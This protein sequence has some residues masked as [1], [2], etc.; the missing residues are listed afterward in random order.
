MTAEQLE[1]F[2]A[3]KP[4]R[5]Y[6]L[7]LADGEEITVSKPRKSLLS[8]DEVALVGLCRRNQGDAIERFR[9]VHVG[10]VKSAEFVSGGPVIP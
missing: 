2:V 6:R 7:V 5:P 3:Q 10:R 1:R 4:F 8:G 9:L